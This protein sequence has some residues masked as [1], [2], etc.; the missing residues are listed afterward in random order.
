LAEELRDIEPLRPLLALHPFAILSD[1][2]GTV[3]PIVENP[4]DAHITDRA[5]D[6]FRALIDRGV[7]VAFVTGRALEMARQM[8]NIPGVSFAANHG[9]N[10]YEDGTIHTPAEVR[11]YVDMAQ[12]VLTEIKEIPVPGVIIE[13]KGPVIAFHFRKAQD[14]ARAA[15]AILAAIQDS[16]SAV[17]FRLQ[18]GRKVLELRPPLAI[19]KGTAVDDLVAHMGAASALC[20]GDDATDMDM[21]RGL[22][23][24]REQGIAGV[25]IAVWSPELNRSVLDATDYY[26]RGVEGVEWLLEAILTALPARSGSAGP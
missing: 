24:L 21:F 9:I 10:I 2:D 7:R 15:I 8:V 20:I 26:V 1:I 19:D 17:A 11:P 18:Q 6:A 4:Q 22:N 25:N 14:E 16:P 5:C 13:D 23:E 3:A 12:E